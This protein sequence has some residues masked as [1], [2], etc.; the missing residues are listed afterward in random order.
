METVNRIAT[1][2]HVFTEFI[3]EKLEDG[4]LYVSLKFN[5]VTHRCACGCSEE[6][7][8]PL[9]PNDWSMTYNGQS[10]SLHPSIGNWS[11]KCRSHYWIRNNKV[12]WA[13]SWSNEKIKAAR[14]QEKQRRNS[15]SVTKKNKGIFDITRDFF[16]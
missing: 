13:E 3:P 1:F 10:V 7:V 5:T 16:K 12:S 2:R 9:S 4:V 15:G 8:T 14:N 11:Y 6:V